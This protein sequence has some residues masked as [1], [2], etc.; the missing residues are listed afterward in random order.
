MYISAGTM[1]LNVVVN[2]ALIPI[3]GIVGAAIATAT[4]RTFNNTIQ[5]FFIY[6]KHGISPFDRNYVVPTAL[7]LGI[8]FSLY[9][10]PISFSSL[11]FVEAIPVAAGI[12]LVF[13]LVLLVTRSIYAV[14]LELI[15]GLLE[16]AGIPVSVSGYLQPFIR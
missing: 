14:E 3:Y 2:V 16:R 11:T 1:F 12:G 6:R 7:M 4:A 10:A 9:I 13:L 8:F 15:D 5:S